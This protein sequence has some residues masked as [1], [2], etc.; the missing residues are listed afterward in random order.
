MMIEEASHTPGQN[1]GTALAATGLSILSLLCFAV[2]LWSFSI[3]VEGLPVV[4]G[5]FYLMVLIAATVATVMAGRRGQW[6]SRR[7]GRNL[8]L[9]IY[10]FPIALVLILSAIELKR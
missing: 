2:F 9:V 1:R 7:H 3:Y 6:R 10:L 8:L 5:F 4:F